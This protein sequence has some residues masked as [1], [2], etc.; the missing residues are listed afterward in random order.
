[1]SP[2]ADAADEAGP[3]ETDDWATDDSLD[4]PKIFEAVYEDSRGISVSTLAFHTFPSKA[5]QTIKF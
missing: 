5:S 2:V 3:L 4:D 1:M